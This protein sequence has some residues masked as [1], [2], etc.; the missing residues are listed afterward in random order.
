MIKKKKTEKNSS[1]S[2]NYRP[3]SQINIEAITLK[4]YYQIEF[5]NTFRRLYSWTSWLHFRNKKIVHIHKSINVI[6]HIELRIVTSIDA[7]KAL[8]KIQHPLHDSKEIIDRRNLPQYHKGYI[9][10]IQNQNHTQWR[11]IESIFS[12][13]RN[14]EGCPS[15]NFYL[16]YL[17]KLYPEQLGKRR[18]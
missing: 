14:K 8:D 5:N 10:K 4:I 6:Y 12:K 2:E 18:K 15:H 17:L 7:E 16:L 3:I 9:W 1:R 13:I 11:K